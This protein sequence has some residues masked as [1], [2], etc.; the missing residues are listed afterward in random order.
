MRRHHRTMTPAAIAAN[1]RNLIKARAARSRT[2]ATSSVKRTATKT[3][4]KTSVKRTATKTSALSGKVA[5]KS[6]GTKE[7]MITLYH[8]TTPAA[9][10]KIVKEGFHRDAKNAI[11]VT[12]ET[13]GNVYFSTSRSGVSKDY[14]LATVSIRVPKRLVRKDPEDPV[15]DSPKSHDWFMVKASDLST[16][17]SKPR[18]SGLHNPGGTGWATFMTPAAK[19]KRMAAYRAKHPVS[20]HRRRAGTRVKK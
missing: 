12:D 10:R 15:Y 18:A 6:T 13:R 1:R 7:E 5:T 9:A 2:T 20:T 8:R 14:G 17:T 16:V 19:R 4:V 3:S 11:T